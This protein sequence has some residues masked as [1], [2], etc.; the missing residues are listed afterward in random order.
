MYDKA[1]LKKPVFQPLLG[2]GTLPQGH[3]LSSSQ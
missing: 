1:G 2:A 3:D